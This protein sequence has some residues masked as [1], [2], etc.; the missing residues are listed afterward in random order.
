[1]GLK[2]LPRRSECV[3]AHVSAVAQRFH[4]RHSNRHDM[5]R[6]SAQLV[7]PPPSS[8]VDQQLILP[9]G[10]RMW[11]RESYSP[12]DPALSGVGETK[13]LRSLILVPLGVGNTKGSAFLLSNSLHPSRNAKDQAHTRDSN[14]VAESTRGSGS[15]CRSCVNQYTTWKILDPA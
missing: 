2:V 6:L 12:G 3:Y 15:L 13:F 10:G 4:S 9:P 5:L 7:D 1:M 14:K 8:V 11:L